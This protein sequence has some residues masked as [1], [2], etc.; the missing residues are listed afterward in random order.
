M[1][2]PVILSAWNFYQ[3]ICGRISLSQKVAI[4]AKFKQTI[5]VETR[6]AA[7]TAANHN[8]EPMSMPKTTTGGSKAT[9]TMTLYTAFCS[10]VVRE[11]TSASQSKDDVGKIHFS[12]DGNLTHL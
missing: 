2:I 9:E 10:P 12:S 6:I 3:S 7:V 5:L 4:A 1:A 11:I 8:C